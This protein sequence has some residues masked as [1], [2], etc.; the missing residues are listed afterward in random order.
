MPC[1]VNFNCHQNAKCEWFE[2]ELRN[3]CVCDAGYEG[4]GHQCVEREVSCLYVSYS[5]HYQ[6]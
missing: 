4:N 1:D 5:W 3:K 6:S 2:A